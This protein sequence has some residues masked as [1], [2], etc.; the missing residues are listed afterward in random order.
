[1]ADNKWSREPAPPPPMFFGEKERN[2]VKQIN[3]EITDRIIGQQIMYYPIDVQRSSFHLIYGECMN[4]TFLPP[5]R[6]YAHVEWE[7][8]ETTADEIGVDRQSKLTIHFHK[9][10]LEDDQNLYVTVG[11]FIAYGDR[12]YEIVKLNM[13]RELFG[14]Y[15]AR[16]EISAKCV[17]AREGTF[18]AE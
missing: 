17:R 4:K 11:D 15:H 3:E 10:R 18:D 8:N 1:M 12:F 2:F 9:R 13:P 7:G 16:F 5:V 14:Q 6:V